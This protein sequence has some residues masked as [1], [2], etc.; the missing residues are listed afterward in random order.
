MASSAR[1]S[2]RLDTYHSG[3]LSFLC[4]AC[5]WQKSSGI[6]AS[7]LRS[8]LPLRSRVYCVVYSVQPVPLGS[9][10]SDLGAESKGA[11][12]RSGHR[13]VARRG[14]AFRALFGAP[15]FTAAAL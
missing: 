14:G 1:S 9:A 8:T 3:I 11:N 10:G 7:P 2:I 4:G 13:N 15:F 12:H 6:A 5:G